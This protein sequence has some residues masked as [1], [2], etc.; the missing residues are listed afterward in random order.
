MLRL[1]GTTTSGRSFDA[2]TILF[3]WNKAQSVPGF[4]ASIYRKDSC[5]AWIQRSAYGDLG[6]Y[7]WEVD[8]IRPVAHQ[9]TDDLSNLQPLHWQNN[10]GKG[11]SYP[12]WSCSISAS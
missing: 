5:G 2:L 10:R 3:V 9:G 6:D 7:G 4:D 8:H 11:D 1:S 12:H